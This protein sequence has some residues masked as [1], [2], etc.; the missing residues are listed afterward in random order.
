MFFAARRNIPSNMLPLLGI[1]AVA[2]PIEVVLVTTTR[3]GFMHYYVAL[4]YVLAVWAGWLFWLVRQ[5]L[6]GLA[7][8]SSERIRNGLTIG[9]VCGIG[10]LALP[11]LDHNITY[12]KGLRALEPPQVV[13]YIREQT[14]PKDTVLILGFEPRLLLFGERRS[15]TRFIHTIPFEFPRFATPELVESYFDDIL[16]NKPALIV[17]PRGYGLNNFTPAD[18]RRIQKQVNQLRGQYSEVGPIGGWMVYRRNE[19]AN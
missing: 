9:L 3:R 13:E 6:F 14:T 18:S 4:L 7:A 16:T 17:D 11:A 12:A 2:L 1:C 15:P 5:A 8:P 19:S 10:V